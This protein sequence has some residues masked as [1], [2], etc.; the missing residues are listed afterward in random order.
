LLRFLV[1]KPASLNAKKYHPRSN[2]AALAAKCNPVLSR[3]RRIKPLR[4]FAAY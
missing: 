1:A 4:R 2:Y 3:G